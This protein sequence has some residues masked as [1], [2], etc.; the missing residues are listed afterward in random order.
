[1]PQIAPFDH[2]RLFID[3]CFLATTTAS[4]SSVWLKRQFFRCDGSLLF[5]L[6]STTTSPPNLLLNPGAENGTLVPW[7]T[8]GDGVAE[9]DN[10]SSISGY[11]PRS[12]TKQFY[13]GYISSYG[14]YSTLTQSVLLLNGTQG[15]TA[16]HLDNGTLRAYISFYQQSYYQFTDTDDMNIRLDFRSS[17]SALISSVS[18]AYIS[19]TS[20]WCFNSGNYSIPIGTRRIDYV[21]VF[22]IVTGTYIDAYVDDNT[23][24]VYWSNPKWLARHIEGFALFFDRVA[25]STTNQVVFFSL[26]SVRCIEFSSTRTTEQWNQPE[27]IRWIIVD[28]KTLQSSSSSAIQMKNQSVVSF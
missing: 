14:T 5:L 24:R 4:T 9:I 23:L 25:F 10:G 19:C 27:T 1:M 20:G 8:G 7:V 11:N 26:S 2:G 13:G 6:A 18:T 15:Y 3:D 28:D 12:G 16:A 17:S 21:M 22:W